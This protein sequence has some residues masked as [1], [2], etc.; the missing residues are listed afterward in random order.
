MINIGALDWTLVGGVG[1]LGWVLAIHFKK[2][3]G[4]RKRDFVTGSF[5][6][7]CLTAIIIAVYHIL[8]S[9]LSLSP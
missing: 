7:A 3:Y 6:V 5:Y 9:L 2:K 8:R 1:V 4:L